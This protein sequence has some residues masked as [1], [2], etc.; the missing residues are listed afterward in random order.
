MKVWAEKPDFRLFALAFAVYLAGI[1]TSFVR[2]YFLVRVIDSRFKMGQAFLLG[3]I[4]RVFNLVIPGGVGGDFVKA[5]YLVRME[6]NRTQ[7]VAS[8]MVIDRVIGLLGLFVLAG[9]AGLVAWSRVPKE[10]HWLIGA[11]WL[12]T[13]RR[14]RVPRP[15]CSP[16]PSRELFHRH[17]TERH[18]RSARHSQ[19]VGVM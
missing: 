11:D 16:R 5:A 19:R 6:I 7:A 2:W 12:I 9:L 14:R 3:F 10:S 4:G 15:R 8:E 17:L 18:N 13:T 1:S